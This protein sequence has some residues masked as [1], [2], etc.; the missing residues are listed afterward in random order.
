MRKSVTVNKY[1]SY[2]LVTCAVAYLI[3]AAVIF[4]FGVA[5]TGFTRIDDDLGRFIVSLLTFSL[6][7]FQ[8]WNGYWY[9]AFLVPWLGSSLLFL[10]LLVR[11]KTQPKR[12]P[13]FSGFS[14]SAYYF[15]MFLVY[16]IGRIVLWWGNIQPQSWQNIL[17]YLIILIGFVGGGFIAGFFSSII[18]DRF[19]KLP[20]EN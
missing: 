3:A 5:Q 2:A 1:I 9:L 8:Y 19:I 10:I 17:F 11:F 18:T 16:V 14:V 12:K 20:S 4:I 6:S 15:V 7:E 13:A